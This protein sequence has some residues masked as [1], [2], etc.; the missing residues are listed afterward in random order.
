ML[1]NFL[2]GKYFAIVGLS[3]SIL[4]LNSNL[5]LNDIF[6]KE[7]ALITISILVISLFQ[8][9]ILPKISFLA[10]GN[11][12]VK[13]LMA[14][15][16]YNSL[17]GRFS[18]VLFRVVSWLSIISLVGFILINLIGIKLPFI[19]IDKFLTSY[20]LYGTLPDDGFIRNNGMF[21]E[22]GAFAGVLTLC[23]VLNFKYLKHYWV[24]Y[25]Y[26]LIFI[27]VA[28]LSTRSTT[29]YLVGFLILVFYNTKPQNLTLSLIV[30]SIIFF[31][32]LFIYETNDFLQD[33]VAH[34]FGQSNEQE[35]G[36]FSNT[37][38]GSI[39]FDFHYFYKHPFIGN[40]FE[41]STRFSDHKYMFEGA[42]GEDVIAS[43]NA[44]SNFLASMGLFFVWGYFLLLFKTVAKKELLFQI[45]FC[46]AIFFNLQGEQWFNYPLYLGLP[47]LKFHKI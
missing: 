36:E 13:I 6:P 37:R 23:L 47:F 46:L 10:V 39:I 19:Q 31:I 7:F 35:I 8:F 4:I 16:I 5:K 42:K 18:Y 24:N 40:G 27:I 26:Y 25:R 22:P 17:K 44:I 34:Q 21:W 12:L 28:L 38:F 3:L 33:K 2:F 9:V 11:L 45:I 15:L 41:I 32:G 29:G 20:I 14:N 30:L 1:P 43:G